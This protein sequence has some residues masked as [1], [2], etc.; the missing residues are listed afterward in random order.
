MEN[1]MDVAEE[2]SSKFHGVKPIAMFVIGKYTTAEINKVSLYIKNLTVV[3][4]IKLVDTFS[5][6]FSVTDY[7]GLWG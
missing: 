7:I 4:Y 3:K 1:V 5:L 6:Q 2:V